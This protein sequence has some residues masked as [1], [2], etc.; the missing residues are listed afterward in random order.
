VQLTPDRQ[1]I[2]VIPPDRTTPSQL[3]LQGLPTE[4]TVAPGL[5]YH[6]LRFELVRVSPGGRYA[7]FSAVGHHNFIGVVELA[8]MEVREI[9]LLTEGD[10]GAFHWASDGRTLAYDYVS[11]GGYRE[12]KGYDIESGEGLVVPHTERKSASHVTFQRWGTQPHEV[13]LR[14]TDIRTDEGRIETVTLIPRR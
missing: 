12:V 8:T 5:F 7:A 14:I 3:S 13:I 4:S 9:D 11:A 10:V 2:L 1:A 6:P